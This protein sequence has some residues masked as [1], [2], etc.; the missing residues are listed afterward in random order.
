MR[1]KTT[2]AVVARKPRADA[3]HNRQ[4]LL[5]AAKALFAKKGSRAS[6]EEIAKAADVGTGTFYRHF[7][8]RDALIAAV[9][10]NETSRLVH[11]AERL[12]KALPP[13]D[14]LREWL[15]LF[16]EFIATKH[17]IRE[18]LDTIVGGAASLYSTSSTEVQRAIDALVRRGI[19]EGVISMDLDPISL[20]HALAGAANL[21][22]DRNGQRSAK[23]LVD[24]IIAGISA[25]GRTI[26]AGS[27]GPRPRHSARRKK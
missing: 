20:L 21:G 13:L 10:Q 9:Y 2:K 26:Q 25:K 5:E 18:V 19:S 12:G 3:E 15:L 7:A 23:N 8:T 16:V 22:A 27:T 14:A 1:G 17:G 11:A 6:L 24:I 4:R